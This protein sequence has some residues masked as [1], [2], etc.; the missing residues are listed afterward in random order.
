LLEQLL[1]EPFAIN[2][3]QSY[4]APGTTIACGD[5]GGV[6]DELG[7][8]V[9]ALTERNGSGYSGVAYLAAEDELG[10]TNVSVFVVPAAAA[11]GVA[12][13]PAEAPAVEEAPVV[14]ATPAAVATPIAAA[15]P[16]AEATPVGI[17]VIEE[18]PAGTSETPPDAT[19]MIIEITGPAT[20]GTATA[21]PAG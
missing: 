13:P 4:D 5:I 14:E 12:V 7:G 15:T 2:V 20:E 21:T 10:R 19:P 18:A 11:G 3:A 16:G 1:A 9:I 17:L 6:L 8:F